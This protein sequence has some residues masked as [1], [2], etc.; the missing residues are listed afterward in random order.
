MWMCT[1]SDKYATINTFMY[2]RCERARLSGYKVKLDTPALFD[3]LRVFNLD[4]IQPY[5]HREGQPVWEFLMP[6]VETAA[7]PPLIKVLARRGVESKKRCTFLY[8]CEGD[9]DTWAWELSKALEENPVY[10]E[11]LRLHS[12]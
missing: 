7:S 10:L 9:D 8:C 5:I 12:E 6:P 1:N 4:S 2:P 11:L 3:G